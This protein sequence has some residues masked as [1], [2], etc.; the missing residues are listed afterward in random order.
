M[1]AEMVSIE[2]T[3]G[4]LN[5]LF[6]ETQAPVYG[7]CADILEQVAKCPV[8]QHFTIEGL[9]DLLSRQ[10][11]DDKLLIEAMFML[12]AHPFSALDVYFPVYDGS[13]TTEIHQMELAEY[14]QALKDG[15]FVDAS[16]QQFDM[17]GLQ[18]RIFPYFISRLTA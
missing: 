18:T 14:I 2:E 9:R 3:R 6:G 1:V 5:K 16:G 10:E 12:L 7:L 13:L 17:T 11:R 15:F 4:R 8:T